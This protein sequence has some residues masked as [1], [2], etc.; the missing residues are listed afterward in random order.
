MLLK[1]VDLIKIILQL[2]KNLES[3]QG[4]LWA[5]SKFKLLKY[6]FNLGETQGLKMVTII[7][8][9]T[10]IYPADGRLIITNV[11]GAKTECYII[12]EN[13]INKIVNRAHKIEKI[14]VLGMFV[15]G[16]FLVKKVK[17]INKQ[18]Q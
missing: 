12:N 3:S 9:L 6:I 17:I 13:I 5:T 14:E 15:L 4:T 8:S 2:E 7:G 11:S 1:K 10:A 16:R 18:M